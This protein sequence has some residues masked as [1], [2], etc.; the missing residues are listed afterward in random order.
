MSKSDLTVYRVQNEQLLNRVSDLEKELQSLRS[1]LKEISCETAI[2]FILNYFVNCHR[3]HVHQVNM[4]VPTALNRFVAYEI[5]KEDAIFWIQPSLESSLQ[6]LLLQRISEL[7]FIMDDAVVK[8]IVSNTELDDGL[9]KIIAQSVEE[10]KTYII[11]QRRFVCNNIRGKTNMFKDTL[12]LPDIS[13]NET[14]T[15]FLNNDDQFAMTLA[16][17]LKL[18]LKNIL[19][20]VLMIDPIALSLW[21]KEIKSMKEVAYSLDVM[22]TDE[23]M[24]SVSARD[25]TH[26]S[27][28]AYIYLG[29]FHLQA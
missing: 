14:K 2:R 28:T 6:M 5:G 18:D 19:S 15:A 8:A 27:R 25:L 17:A 21:K 13:D 11:R 16:H 4:Q 20:S 3:K 29:R 26:P 23:C 22:G 9:P 12:E 7:V 24:V 1:S 10:K